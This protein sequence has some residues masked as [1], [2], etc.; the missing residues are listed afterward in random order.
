MQKLV[1]MMTAMVL[2][3][4]M[5][6]ETPIVVPPIDGGFLSHDPCGPPCFFGITP[7]VTTEAE[8]REIMEQHP[9]ISNGCED[10]DFS[11]EGGMRGIRCYNKYGLRIGFTDDVV[12]GIG[13]RPTKITLQQVLNAYGIPTS[14]RVGIVS[15]PDYPLRVRMILCFD[16]ISADLI[17]SDQ[18]GKEFVV[19]G[20]TATAS[21]GYYPAGESC[22]LPEDVTWNG[23]GAY[24][25]AKWP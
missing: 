23:Y 2:A 16:Q 10:F 8:A 12:G 5:V 9:E 21:I 6:I 22:V 25:P 11:K 7:G 17:L 4:C 19:T 1:L 18:D 13:F 15:L 20:D 3:G 14:L 24:P